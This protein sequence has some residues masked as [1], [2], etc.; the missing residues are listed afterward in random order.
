MISKELEK[1]TLKLTIEDRV[2]LAQMLLDSVDMPD[3]EI[4]ALWVAES[5]KRYRA[6]KEGRVQGIPLEQVRSKLEK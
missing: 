1:L 2:H 5:E 3:K 6:Y 4:E